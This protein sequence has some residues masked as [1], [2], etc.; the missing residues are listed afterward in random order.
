MSEIET[1]FRDSPDPAA[2]VRGYLDHVRQVL[3]DLDADAIADLIQRLEQ[4]RRDGGT[5]FLLGNGGSAATASH[6]ANDLLALSTTPPLRVWCLTDS[7]AVLTAR[8]ND[9]G[10]DQVFTRQLRDRVGP[11]DLVVAISASGNSPNVL[12]AV[13][14]A[15]E[16]GASTFGL[17]G[18]DGGAL[19]QRCDAALTVRTDPGEYGP[20]E[21]VHVLVE[22]IVANHMALAGARRT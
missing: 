2:F 6:M 20:V 1:I 21:G 17:C 22:H 15:R 11:G 10:Y 12:A 8:A 14:L 3:A 13:D 7:A 4:V 18:F 9:C 16:A 19:A 5:V